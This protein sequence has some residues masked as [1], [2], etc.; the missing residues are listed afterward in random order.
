MLIKFILFVSIYFL[1][2]KIIEKFLSI[3]L[4]KKLSN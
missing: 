2:K 4:S 1:V 3:K